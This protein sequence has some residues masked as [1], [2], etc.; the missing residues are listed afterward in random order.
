L[1]ALGGAKDSSKDWRRLGVGLIIAFTG[2]LQTYLALLVILTTRL[3][4]GIGYGM[5]AKDDP[6]PSF[7]GKFYMDLFKNEFKAKIM[8][9]LTIGVLLS[10]SLLPLLCHR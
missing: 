7:L 1:W 10:L 5:P 2:L 6:K 4:T 3:S 9:R 8:T